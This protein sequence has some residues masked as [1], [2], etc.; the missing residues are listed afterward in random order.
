MFTA[1]WPVFAMM[2]IM[3]NWLVSEASKNGRTLSVQY[4]I[5]F[6]MYAWGP[7]N[8]F[9][10]IH[11]QKAKCQRSLILA[12]FVTHPGHSSFFL[13]YL[14][15]SVAQY[16]TVKP[17]PPS[18]PTP[19]AYR[20]ISKLKLVPPLAP[21]EDGTHAFFRRMYFFF[22]PARVFD[23]KVKLVGLGPQ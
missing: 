22:G 13:L 23:K 6:I 9:A 4:A 5:D 14:F 19:T 10:R 2:N 16:S 20:L 3:R 8:G 12:H 1:I 21:S 18:P 17:H 15:Y 7:D 11:C